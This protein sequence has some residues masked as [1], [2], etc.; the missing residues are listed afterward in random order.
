MNYLEM[1]IGQN[2]CGNTTASHGGTAEEVVANG[3]FIPASD[4]YVPAEIDVG[5]DWDHMLIWTEESALVG[6]RNISGAVIWLNRG[7]LA[8]KVYYT[9]SSGTVGAI[10]EMLNGGPLYNK[11]GNALTF[12]T[13]V[14]FGVYT[15]GTTYHWIAWREV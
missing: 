4:T 8:Y 14:S 9:N 5:E 11:V 12:G 1:L 6:R 2:I 15:S 3:S 7:T 13:D 10:G